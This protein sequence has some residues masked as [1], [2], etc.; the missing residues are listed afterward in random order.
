MC[1]PSSTAASIAATQCPEKKIPE[2]FAITTL[3][4]NKLKFYTDKLTSVC[5]V[6]VKF[7]QIPR[8]TSRDFVIFRP[9]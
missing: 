8:P 5:T 3:A 2:Y 9:I 4:C 7:V 6:H 1:A